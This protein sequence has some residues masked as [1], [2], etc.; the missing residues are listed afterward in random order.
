VVDKLQQEFKDKGLVVLTVNTSE[1]AETI[2]E[3]L[4]GRGYTFPV[5]LDENN[6]A[7]TRYAVTGVPQ[8]YVIDQQRNITLHLSD[9]GSHSEAQI[10]AALTKALFGK[11]EVASAPAAVIALM[12]V[13]AIFAQ[14]NGSLSGLLW[15]AAFLAWSIAILFVAVL[16][17]LVTS[18]AWG[19]PQTLAN[20]LFPSTLNA[21]PEAASLTGIVID[22]SDKPIQGAKV[23]IDELP[24][25]KPFE[26]SSDG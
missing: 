22:Q 24:E 5:L 13:L 23:T 6:A 25:M 2:R 15:L 17:M 4:K 9:Y 10:R 19:K 3:F 26:T 12:Y 18:Y 8:S 14:S 16:V 1:D 11:E 20:R 21:I 7:A